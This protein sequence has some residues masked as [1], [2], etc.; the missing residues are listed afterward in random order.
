MEA[1]AV[2]TNMA[3]I[4]VSQLGNRPIKASQIKERMAKGYQLT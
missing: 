1:A 2:A 4:S 3:A